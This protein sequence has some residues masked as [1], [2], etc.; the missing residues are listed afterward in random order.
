MNKRRNIQRHREEFKAE[1]KRSRLDIARAIYD[2]RG[3]STGSR[4]RMVY[5]LALTKRGWI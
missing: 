3:N 2:I 1:R 5:D 4:V